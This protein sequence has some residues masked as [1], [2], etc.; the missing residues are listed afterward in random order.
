MHKA[1]GLVA[2][3]PDNIPN[4]PKSPDDNP[5]T[6]KSPDDIPSTPKTPEFMKKTRKRKPK[7]VQRNLLDDDGFLSPV[8]N[9]SVLEL[10]GIRKIPATPTRAS[11][12]TPL[13]LKGTPTRVTPR[14]AILV[15]PLKGTPPKVTPTKGT[16]DTP[17][18]GTPTDTP[19]KGTPTRITPR[20][21]LLVT[22]VKGTPPKVTP[23]KVTPD[24]P[25]KG[26]P[27]K[28]ILV[29]TTPT[30]TR[31][32][33]T[34]ASKET[35]K[36]TPK[37]VT[38]KR[39][40][41]KKVMPQKIMSKKP[42]P[43]K[44]TTKKVVTPI[45]ISEVLTRSRESSKTSNK[46]ESVEDP[47]LEAL[48]S[49]I[50]NQ[51]QKRKSPMKNKIL[52]VKIGKNVSPFKIPQESPSKNKRTTP[53]KNN[54]CVGSN[55]LKSPMKAKDLMNSKNLRIAPAASPAKVRNAFMSPRKVLVPPSPAK[56]VT[57]P[58]LTLSKTFEF[59][60]QEPWGPPM[61]PETNDA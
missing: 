27:S 39:A 6:P 14:K 15:T 24:T 4:T 9:N 7:S 28:G 21:A 51:E 38:P 23:T 41:P 12:E 55:S 2:K 36:I 10:K 47:E 18:K 40:L 1:L 45:K 29:K 19:L 44:L 3:S 25:G 30:R 32:T 42:T 56:S 61:T 17:G 50:Q 53:K 8:K 31:T 5:N 59:Y 52:K 26:A 37:K 49:I 57:Q 46:P 20:K 54:S 34:K 11:P 33:P 16:P 13:K 22:P 58:L 35:S 60:E 48:S 43:D